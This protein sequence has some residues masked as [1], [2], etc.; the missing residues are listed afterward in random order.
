MK[1]NTNVLSC[2]LKKTR[3]MG[4]QK[5]VLALILAVLIT[6]QLAAGNIV[7]DEP[8]QGTPALDDSQAHGPRKTLLDDEGIASWPKQNFLPCFH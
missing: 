2:S 1:Q 3:S 5:V 4:I 7:V 6:E 8:F